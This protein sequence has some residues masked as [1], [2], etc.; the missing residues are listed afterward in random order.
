MKQK[1][2]SG[3]AVISAMLL[4]AL[5]TVIVGQLI[6]QQQLLISELE[7]QQNATQAQWIADAAIQWA[8]PVLAEDNKTSTIDHYKE[9]WATRLPATPVE[10]G[11]ISGQIVDMQQFLNL[12]NLKNET[13][14][15]DS[16]N[17]LLNKLTLTNNLT[18]ALVD[19]LD[20]DDLSNGAEGA[21]SNYYSNQ[22]PAY[23]AA[24]QALVELGNL[25][26]VKG[27]DQA[28]INKLRPFTTVLPKNTE[29]NVNAASAEV[30]SFVLP[31]TS[32]QDAQ[33][34]V[35]T[36][37]VT[38]FT[39]LADFKERMPKPDNDVGNINLSV[40][41]RYFLVTCIAQ[42][43]RTIL[44]VEALLYRDDTGWPIVLWKRIG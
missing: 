8:R 9:L 23:L 10:G 11:K 13:S 4:A 41:S 7:N 22:S 16:L 19:W 33:N 26:R 44:R 17:R 28:S 12:N 20:E 29:L 21:E 3:I 1:Y 18:P 25:I 34:M 39:S 35:A 15:Q 14:A 30:L 36:R 38:P 31:N 32:L 42:V 5:T 40:N 24:N 6:W 43:D 2:Q 37:N 27:F